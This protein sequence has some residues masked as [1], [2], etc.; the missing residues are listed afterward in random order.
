MVEYH[1]GPTNAGVECRPEARDVLIDYIMT[2]E[3]MTKEDV[4]SLIPPIYDRTTE[5]TPTCKR[6]A[7]HRSMELVGSNESDS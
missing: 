6:K 5:P 4:I 3:D 2:K 7:C 1:G